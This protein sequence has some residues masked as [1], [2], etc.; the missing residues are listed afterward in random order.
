MR[1]TYVVL[2]GLIA[3]LVVVQAAAIAL[4]FGGLAHHVAEGGTFDKTMM[5]SH[6]S[7]FTGDIGFPIHSLNGGLVIPLVAIALFAVAFFARFH[8]A[9]RRAGLVL[10]L[11][12][13]QV[14]LGYS[15]VDLPY[16]GAVHGANA[17]AL[18]ATTL[19]AARAARRAAPESPRSEA[20]EDARLSVG[21][22]AA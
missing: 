9:V 14:M 16:A 12:V 13:V 5:E 19:L 4:G 1:R 15:I 17:L 11:V 6:E 21:D 8:H 18:F 10:V 20:S 22:G 2:A 3:G 7:A